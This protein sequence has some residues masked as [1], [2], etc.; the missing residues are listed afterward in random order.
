MC[1]TRLASESPSA[2]L[3][4]AILQTLPKALIFCSCVCV[5]VCVTHTH[6]HTQLDTDVLFLLSSDRRISWSLF[7]FLFCSSFLPH[8]FILF[9]EPRLEETGAHLHLY[10][11][12]YCIE[13]GGRGGRQKPQNNGTGISI[14]CRFLR[15]KHN[16]GQPPK[17]GPHRAAHRLPLCFPYCDW[18]KR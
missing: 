6:T 8:F 7:F 15:R 13:G 5:C 16:P 10:G 9:T 2:L 4:P 18:T 3:I 17:D 12:M 1:V 11:K 14:S